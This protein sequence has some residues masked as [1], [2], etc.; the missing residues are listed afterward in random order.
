MQ[1]YFGSEG[2]TV[3]P[4][5]GLIFIAAAVTLAGCSGNP[6]T[7]T[8][9]STAAGATAAASGTPMTATESEF[10]MTL[11][12]KTLSAGTYTLKGD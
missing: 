11:P 9:P 12:S 4:L 10:T 5:R 6:A 7:T 1:N 2:T 3:K 8:V